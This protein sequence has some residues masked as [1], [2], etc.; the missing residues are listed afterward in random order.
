VAGTSRQQAHIRPGTRAWSFLALGE[1][2]RQHGGNDGYED[3]PDSYYR[4]D[5]TVPNHAGPAA[6]DICVLRDSRGV[7]GVSRIDTLETVPGASKMRRRCPECGSTAFKARATLSPPFR[8]SVCKT[9]FTRPR[10]ERVTVCTYRSDHAGSWIAVDGALPTDALE[11]ACLSR[12]RQHAIR[13]LQPDVLRA[14]L[15]ARHVRTDR[16]WWSGPDAARG[17]SIP[18]GRRS[19]R[20]LLRVGQGAFRR[21]LLERFG[22]ACAISGPQP[23]EV[24]HAAHLNRFAGEPVHDVSCGLLLRADLHL[25]FDAGLIRIGEDLQITVAATL[26][27]H[28]EL[29]RYHGRCL[30][31]DPDD[32]LLP[33]TRLHLARR[34]RALSRPHDPAASGAPRS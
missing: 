29:W 7:L 11:T 8:C 3:R 20:A 28:R 24:L 15:V 23:V 6:G 18:G 17:G 9:R 32:P 22:A 5:S 30:A 12:A 13:A 1:E 25:L 31:L 14:L 2:E 4:W 16:N 19:G 26:R 21:S 10:S 34:E 33:R 27:S